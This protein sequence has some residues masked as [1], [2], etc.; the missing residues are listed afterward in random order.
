MPTEIIKQQDED[1]GL[2]AKVIEENHARFVNR[3]GSLNVH[4]KGSLARGTFSLY[5]AILNTSW[6]RFYAGV[7]GFYLVANSLFAL[8]YTA[9]GFK[10]FP[11]LLGLSFWDRFEKLFFYSIQVLTTLGSSPL[12]PENA[13]ANT[14]LAVEAIVGIL[15]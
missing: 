7:L 5:H 2:G 4:K 13:W 10:A 9:A 3:D 11:Q 15:S 8:A 12:H 14:L 1:L 6:T